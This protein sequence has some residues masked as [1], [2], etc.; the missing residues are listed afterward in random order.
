L[1]R[2]AEALVQDVAP[3]TADQED[4]RHL[5]HELQVHEIELRMQNEELRRTRADLEEALAR[6]TDLYDFAPVGYLTLDR[7]D[8]IQEANSTVATMLGVARADLLGRQLSDFVPAT[9]QDDWYL[10]RRRA[11]AGAE[12]ESVELPFRKA[13]AT[14]FAARLECCPMPGA[15]AELWRC[16]VVVIDVTARKQAEE[17]LRKSRVD[18]ERL[19]VERTAALHQSEEQYRNLAENTRD[20]LYAMSA[21]G[22]LEYVGPQAGLY[23]FDPADLVGRY[24]VEIVYPDDRAAVTAGLHKTVADGQPVSSE[25]RVAAGDGRVIWFEERST[26][27]RDADGAVTQLVGVL[28]DVTGRKQLEAKQT[29]L[30]N[31]LR[32]LAARLAVAQDEEQRRIAAGL[33]DNVAQWLAAIRIKTAL[34]RKSRSAAEAER[35]TDEIDEFVRAAAAEVRS[36]TFQLGSSTLARL[37]LAA[38]LRELCET[39]GERHGLRVELLD[40]G[41][42]K[43]LSPA[44]SL[45]LFKASR[46]LLFNVAKHAGVDEARV[47]LRRR[48]AEVEITVE[49]QGRGFEDGFCFEGSQTATGLG[50]FGIHE[51]MRELGGTMAVESHPQHPTRVTVCAPLDGAGDA[52][53]GS[54][55]GQESVP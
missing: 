24:F 3:E 27:Q 55:E 35:L 13:D 52:V 23:G 36:L 11:M 49:D 4:P 32:R 15:A 1:R 48:D 39:F 18:L 7:Q 28:R 53:A 42:P 54:S 14:A 33:H 30:Q 25:F 51:R 8:V 17:A 12:K 41:Q 50:L 9:A 47:Y 44:A 40:D 37:G 38:G 29:G 43:P 26:I 34:L 2:Q 10:S 5:L 31:Q 19:I 45:V 21:D 16:L 20:V 22:L 6:Y 46:E